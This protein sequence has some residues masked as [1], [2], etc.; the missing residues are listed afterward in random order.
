[1]SKE[2]KK[3]KNRRRRLIFV[4]IVSLLAVS[5]LLVLKVD[6]DIKNLMRATYLILIVDENDTIEYAFSSDRDLNGTIFDTER[7]RNGTK[8]SDAISKLG[9]EDGIR[10]ILETV[11]ESE[12]IEINY[13]LV[14]PDTILHEI[15]GKEIV[16]IEYI[17]I[18]REILL[19]FTDMYKRGEITIFP[20]NF[21][22]KLAK[23]IPDSIIE[24]F[25]SKFFSLEPSEGEG[26]P[27]ILLVIA[28]G[29][30]I[31]LIVVGMRVYLVGKRK[32][33]TEPISLAPEKH[34]QYCGHEI[35]SYDVICSYCGK[36]QEDEA[37]EKTRAEEPSVPDTGICPFCKREIREG[38][39]A[40]PYCGTRLKDDTQ[41][42]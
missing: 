39:I 21:T 27:T 3:G 16:R 38:W 14:I 12:G 5:A 28:G 19:Q 29:I 1:M 42:Y 8:I 32:A 7:Q 34:C 41:V 40:C 30:A 36:K 33:E 9:Y 11:S 37:V 31:L 24:Y 13:A 15:Y 20:S 2:M 4:T 26:F 23:Y 35:K 22:F 17:R 6:S 25:S 18:E 10:K